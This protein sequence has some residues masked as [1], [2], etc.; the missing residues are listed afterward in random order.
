M[1]QFNDYL[2][3]ILSF[4]VTLFTYIIAPLIL[5]GK[6]KSYYFKKEARKIAIIN[7][8]V[9]G[10]LWILYRSYL[11]F[12]NTVTF[13]PFLYYLV[14]M[15]ILTRKSEYSLTEKPKDT[16]YTQIDEKLWKDN[17]I[18]ESI[19]TDSDQNPKN[20]KVDTNST[21]YCMNCGNQV[22]SS[23]NYCKF[24]GYDLNSHREKSCTICGS[25]IDSSSNFCSNCGEKIEKDN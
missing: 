15:W 5:R 22:Q 4:A 21:K 23:S 25:I 11:N 10:V 14:N 16:A 7:S 9:V 1:Y 8:I 13:A 17:F 18:N 20:D 12:D 2:I 6:N 3:I 24:C 19:P